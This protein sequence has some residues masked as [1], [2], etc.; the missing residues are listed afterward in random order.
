MNA[1]NQS[2]HAGGVDYNSLDHL[3]R[4]AGAAAA[5]TD[6]LAHIV[7][8]LGFEVLR[9]SR[10]ESVF[11]VRHPATGMIFGFLVEG[12]GTKNLIAENIALRK[13]SGKTH[14]DVMGWDTVAMHVN[15]AI[16]LGV[17]LIVFGQHPALAEGDHLSGGNGSDLIRG[18]V[19]A[20]RYCGM[21]Y[22]PGETP[23][24]SGII[25]PGT[26]CLSGAG[27]GVVPEERHLINPEELRP[28]LRIVMLGSSGIHSNGI[29][30]VRRIAQRLPDGYLTLLS[31]GKTLGEAVM[32][33]THIYVHF[34]RE[35]Q[36]RGVKLFY[37]AHISGHGWA[38]VMRA[39]K[40]LTYRITH[41]PKPH[42]I[43]RFIQEQDGLSDWDMYIGYNMGAGFCLFVE[44]CQ[45][46]LLEEI[47]R[48]CGFPL[49]DVG[50]TEEGPR[51]V[52]I[53]PLGIEYGPKDLDLR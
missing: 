16:T 39:T 24:L 47:G 11:L 38:K 42:P 8:E 44:E 40:E 1:E 14:Y 9:W 7:R 10:G 3:K 46:P 43:F 19:E 30:R 6:Y 33:R 51:R 20:C 52:I 41:V 45:V 32:T 27:F 18:T 26:M 29:S 25:V 53:E 13:A 21:V 50:I 15:D 28:G 2:E 5:N 36:K 48:S 12:L 23:Q 49:W 35:C 37:T 34:V 31:D 4:T 17:M 22:G